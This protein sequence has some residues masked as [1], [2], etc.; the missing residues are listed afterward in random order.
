VANFLGNLVLGIAEA[1]EEGETFQ[2]ALFEMDRTT[3]S[4]KA[5][6]QAIPILKP[7]AKNLIA[8]VVKRAVRSL[9]GTE[10][11]E[12]ITIRVEMG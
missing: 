8:R 7:F 9:R 10:G 2:T 6:N 4:L 3:L 11:A 5:N 12:L 1:L